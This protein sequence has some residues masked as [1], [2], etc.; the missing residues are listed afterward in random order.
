[1]EDFDKG[2]P[3]NS[4]NVVLRVEKV[5]LQGFCSVLA[6]SSAILQG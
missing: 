6:G 4:M 3:A 1:M 2:G 5:P